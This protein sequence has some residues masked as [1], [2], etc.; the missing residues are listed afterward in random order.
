TGSVP[1]AWHDQQE[2]AEAWAWA[3]PDPRPTVRAGAAVMVAAEALAGP[4][5]SVSGGAVPESLSAS[6]WAFAPSQVDPSPSSEQ[7]DSSPPRRSTW[8]VPDRA[9]P[10]AL[11]TK[12]ESM[13]PLT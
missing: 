10:L 8:L 3:V 12:P 13:L 6:A 5:W 1:P 9:T 7:P 11:R 2:R 4:S